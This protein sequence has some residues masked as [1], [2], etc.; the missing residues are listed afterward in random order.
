MAE[1]SWLEAR[2]SVHCLQSG[3]LNG[4]GKSAR[5]GRVTP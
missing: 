5:P 1:T 3:S 4:S 2:V